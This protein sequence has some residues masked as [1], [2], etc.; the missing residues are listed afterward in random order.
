MNIQK[1]D[2]GNTQSWICPKCGQP[3]NEH[4]ALSRIDNKTNICSQCGMLEALSDAVKH[5]LIKEK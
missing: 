3:T 1:D 4:P 2:N 5:G